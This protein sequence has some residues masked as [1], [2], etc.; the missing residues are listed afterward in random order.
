MGTSL[1]DIRLPEFIKSTRNAFRFCAN[2]RYVE[3]SDRVTQ[4]SYQAFYNC[5]SLERITLSRNLE[6]I[7]FEAFGNCQKTN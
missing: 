3:M 1:V 2:L 6:S 7:G 5:L 4:I